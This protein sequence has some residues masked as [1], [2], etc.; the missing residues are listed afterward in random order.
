MPDVEVCPG[1]G[2]RVPREEGPTHRYLLA[3]VRRGTGALGVAGADV[4]ARNDAAGGHPGHGDPDLRQQWEVPAAEA[5]S[6]DGELDRL[7]AEWACSAWDAWSPH[8]E[9]VRAFYLVS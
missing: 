9:T 8:H 5:A 7:V 6:S 3:E 2:A 4:R 1:C